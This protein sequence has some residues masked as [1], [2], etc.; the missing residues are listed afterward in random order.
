[1]YSRLSVKE[2][3]AVGG[4]RGAFNTASEFIVSTTLGVVVVSCCQGGKVRREG[5]VK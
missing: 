4:G 1:L 5:C 3:V 2:T